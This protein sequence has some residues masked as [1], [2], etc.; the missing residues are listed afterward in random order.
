MKVYALRL[1]SADKILGH[2][3]ATHLSPEAINDIYAT[4]VKSLTEGIVSCAAE[5]VTIET[6]SS[7]ELDDFRV[8]KLEA[9]KKYLRID[10][11]ATIGIPLRVS[12]CFDLDT[13]DQKGIT[14][15]PGSEELDDQIED[16]ITHEGKSFGIIEDDIY[17]GDTM[18]QTI[19]I[20]RSHD[21]TIDTII[22]AISS[23]RMLGSIPVL[24]AVYYD[25]EDLLDLA[26][27]RD[28]I[29]GAKYGGLVVSHKGIKARVPYCTPFVDIA[30]RSS[31][32]PELVDRFS[33]VVISANI[34]LHQSLGS[35]DYPARLFYPSTV[36]YHY[37][38]SKS[39]TLRDVFKELGRRIG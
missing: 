32:N 31:I 37:G 22:S 6:H 36:L 8:S 35:I 30:R 26:D 15:Q 19:A 18:R 17:T 20:L 28:F 39:D 21:I 23:V 1:E 3:A 16:I 2:L 10:S 33:K 13:G 38:L 24:S 4:F 25:P 27:P 7:L 9:S 11:Q 29:F 5:P 14:S 34:V 12:R